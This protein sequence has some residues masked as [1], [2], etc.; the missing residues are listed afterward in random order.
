VAAVQWTIEEFAEW[1]ADHL[2]T[3]AD[4]KRWILAARRLLGTLNIEPGDLLSDALLRIHGGQRHLNRD[5]PIEVNLYGVM[6]SIAS[7]WHKRRKRKPEISLD[8]MRADDGGGRGGDVMEVLQVSDNDQVPGPE[9][10]LA[11]KQE[12]EALQA[13]FKDRPEAEL[14]LLGRAEGLQGAELAD[15][16]ELNTSQ[17]ATVQRLISRRLAGYRRDE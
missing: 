11:Y 5:V 2:T 13:L 16:A 9:E 1:Q 17:L 12:L 6:R 4:Q 7:S 14:V 3:R 8:E 10:E 15:F